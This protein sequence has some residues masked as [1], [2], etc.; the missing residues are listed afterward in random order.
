MQVRIITLEETS[1]LVSKLK[2]IF[3]EADVGIQRGIDVRKSPTE[4][5]C[6]SNLITHSVVHTLQHGRKWHH[7]VAT[8]GAVGIAQANRLAIEEDFSK[9]L[10]L[11]EADCYILNGKKLKKEVDQLLI[12]ADK[13]DM[14]VF[15]GWF[16]KSD[17]KTEMWLPKGFKVIE[18]KFWWLQCVLYTPSGRQKVSKLLNK[19]LEM[20]IDSL[21]GAEALMGNLT[22]VGQVK[23]RSTTQ[24]LH[25][26]SVQ[27]QNP[28]D[29]H[30]HKVGIPLA[31]SVLVW[32]LVSCRNKA[33]RK[34][35]VP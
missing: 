32:Y 26:S 25:R 28:F 33:S 16:G 9:P 13:F 19:P 2:Y 14:A 7:E 18:G 6:A 21:Y 23:G 31:I 3:P 27:S 12:H 22:V 1:K 35:Q 17:K 4:L 5:L 15:G 8:K 11:L 34:H 29:V 20:Q 30:L 24:I 10:L